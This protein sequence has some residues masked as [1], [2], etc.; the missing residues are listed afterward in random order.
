MKDSNDILMTVDRQ[1]RIRSIG[2]LG[3]AY[4]MRQVGDYFPVICRYDG[5]VQTL[6]LNDYQNDQ[7][8][9]FW[10]APMRHPCGDWD[11]FAVI[12]RHEQAP[13]HEPVTAAWPWRREEL[14]A[15][16]RRGEFFLLYQPEKRQESPRG[17][18][19]EALLRWRHGEAQVLDAAAF[20]PAIEAYGLDIELG[21][22]VLDEVCQQNRRWQMRGLRPMSISVNLSPAQLAHPDLLLRT[23]EILDFHGLPAHYLQFELNARCMHSDGYADAKVLHHLKNIGVR[24]ML[25]DCENTRRSW[26]QLLV[27]PIDAIKVRAEDWDDTL[28]AVARGLGKALI[29]KLHGDQARI[30]S[31]YQPDAQQGNEIC[32]PLP[33]EQI[34]QLL[35][36]SGWAA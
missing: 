12:E 34:A 32:K 14:L 6:S 5:Q 36:Q 7:P 20:M 27:W 9:E 21:W 1:G 23:R 2:E 24:L 22:W 31:V 4:F 30:D 29:V 25:D 13:L 35:D 19:A 8:R 18:T 28:M 10:L 16:M 26:H 15:A 17:R 11:G 33:A 3:S